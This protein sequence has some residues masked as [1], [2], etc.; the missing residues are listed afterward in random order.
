M[1]I[2]LVD[3]RRIIDDTSNQLNY[4]FV[5]DKSLMKAILIL[6]LVTYKCTSMNLVETI[7]AITVTCKKWNKV[8][9]SLIGV[10]FEGE[11]DDI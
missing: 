11:Y 6:K 2:F 5:T 10:K 7:L 1:S 4:H 9:L 3:T 8:N